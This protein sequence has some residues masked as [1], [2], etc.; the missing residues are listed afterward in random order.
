MLYP[1]CLSR[2][3][4]KSFANLGKR[5]ISILHGVKV[6]PDSSPAAGCAPLCCCCLL[7]WSG[8]GAALAP[9]KVLKEIVL[10]L[11]VRFTHPCANIP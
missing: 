9:L 2:G 1:N 4:A 5:K 7:P 8:S 3:F 6:L 11:A 10:S